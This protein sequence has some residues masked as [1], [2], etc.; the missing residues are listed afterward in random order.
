MIAFR[1]MTHGPPFYLR[2]HQAPVAVPVSEDDE[3]TAHVFA[4]VDANEGAA[5]DHTR[6]AALAPIGSWS[7]LGRAATNPARFTWPRDRPDDVRG[8]A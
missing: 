2:V 5:S 6:Q 3:A 4:Q 1:H 8:N 7:D